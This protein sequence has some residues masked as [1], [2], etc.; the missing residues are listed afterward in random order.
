MDVE[1]A[2]IRS[3]IEV[4]ILTQ[5]AI[6]AICRYAHTLTHNRSGECERREVTLGTADEVFAKERQV[7]DRGILLI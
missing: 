5:T 7:L 6:E 4:D 3:R 2:L 1:H